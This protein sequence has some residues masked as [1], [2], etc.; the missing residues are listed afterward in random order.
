MNSLNRNLSR[1][2]R[3]NR[4]L[5]NYQRFA[6]KVYSVPVFAC[7][8][9]IITGCRPMNLD[10]PVSFRSFSTRIKE[11]HVK[12]NSLDFHVHPGFGIVKAIGEGVDYVIKPASP[13]EYP[14]A[15]R[16]FV[17]IYGLSS[18]SSDTIKVE[19]SGEKK[20]TLAVSSAPGSSRLYCE[21]EVPIKYDISADLQNDACLQIMGMEA[22]EVDVTTEDGDLETRGLKSHNI[23]IK[24]QHGNIT[25]DGTLQGNIFI[26]AKS[27]NLKAKRLQGLKMNIIAE[28]LNTNV[29][30][31]Y[32][33][34]G[35]ITAHRG[36]IVINHLHGSTSLTLNQGKLSLNG[37]HGHLMGSVG[38]GKVDVQVTEITEDSTLELQEGSLLVSVLD[39]PRHNL[40]VTA[41]SVEVSEEISSQPTASTSSTSLSLKAG[42]GTQANTFT[43]EVVNG[44]AKVQRQDW[45]STLG[46]NIGR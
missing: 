35:Q 3:I 23:H 32:M 18:S 30:S 31:S 1:L 34:E 39:E 21:I 45:F 43:A 7:D 42:G 6:P 36:D 9:P 4:N 14:D 29:Q 19:L 37:L 28:E 5:I 25:A 27:T 24:T 17:S 33:N 22:D 10:I 8:R 41:P 13:Q 44:S 12:L 20:D 46:I 11:E 38:T 40:Q 16:A 15:D 26:I 2:M